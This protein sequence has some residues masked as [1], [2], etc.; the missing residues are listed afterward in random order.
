MFEFDRKKAIV[1]GGTYRVDKMPPVH[2]WVW[3]VGE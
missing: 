2:I 3:M 1:I